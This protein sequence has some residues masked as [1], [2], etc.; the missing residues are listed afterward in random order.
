MNVLPNKNRT[1]NVRALVTKREEERN[2]QNNPIFVTRFYANVW[3]FQE[4]T[5]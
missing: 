4:A 2:M 1:L 3:I 5:N